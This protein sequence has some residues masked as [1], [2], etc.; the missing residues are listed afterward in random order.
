MRHVT[1]FLVA[2]AA[3]AGAIALVTPEPGHAEQEIYVTKIPAGYRDWRLISV[4]HEAGALN[5]IRAILGNDAAVKAYR[6]SKLPFPDGADH[7]PDRLEVRPVRGEQQDLRPRAVLRCRET[8]PDVVP[9]VHGQGLEEIRRDG[10]LGLCAIRQ[11]RSSR[12]P[13]KDLK[14]CF[15]CHQAIKTRDFL[16]TRYTP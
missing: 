5:D 6:E 16:F 9:P 3:V 7:C 10:R 11:G 15:P 4:A 2:V 13:K 1:L 14:A 8:P 12:D